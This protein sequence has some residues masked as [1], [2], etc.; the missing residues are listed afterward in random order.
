GA[1]SVSVSGGT[2]NLTLVPVTTSRNIVVGGTSDVGGSLTITNADLA[3]LNGI[4]TLNIGETSGP[5]G[6]DTG[7]ITLADPSDTANGGTSIGSGNVALIKLATTGST[8][9]AGDSASG[10][11]NLDDT[12]LEFVSAVTVNPATGNTITLTSNGSLLFDSTVND[13]SAGADA[14]V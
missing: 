9:L 14:L 7:T 1:G 5:A 11:I 13:S 6:V 10:A 2:W 3:A 8:I 4:G 12:D